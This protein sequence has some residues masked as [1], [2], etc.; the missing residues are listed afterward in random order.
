MT[1]SSAVYKIGTR[2][3]NLALFQARQT[4]AEFARRFPGLAF[5]F[6][7]LDS[8]GD[9]D[10]KTDLRQSPADFFTRD[11]DNAV[12]SGTL[13]C[14]V[15]S[16]KD[17]P[18]PVSE[19]LDWVW[20]PWRADP[21]DALV[22]RQGTS[23]ADLPKAP[24][25]GVSSERRA[26]YCTEHFPEGVQRNLRGNIEERL[27]QLD[28]GDVDLIVMAAAA[29]VRLDL[30]ARISELIPLAEMPVP[31]GQ[32]RLCL[33]F[34]AGDPTFLR[35]RALFTTA[36]RFV[37]A[38]IGAAENATMAAVSALQTCDIC[39]HDSLMDQD[40]LDHL[41]SQARPIYVGKRAGAHYRQQTDINTLLTDAARKGYRVV[42]LKGGDP[43][44]FGRLAEELEALGE[45]NIPYRVVPGLSSLNVLS[46]GSGILLTRRG[47]ANGF[48][49]LT[50]RKAGG[51]MADIS[52]AERSRYPVVAYMS[53]KA[54]GDV[55]EQLVKD[56][57]SESTPAAM[58]FG[59]GSGQEFA[60][61]G[62]LLD[63]P[64]QVAE[65]STDLPG[66][67]VTGAEAAREP[68][69]CGPLRGQRVLLT[70]SEAILGKASREVVDRG[71]VPVPLPMLRLVPT[72]A[73]RGT[74]ARLGEFD[75]LVVTSP[76]SVRILMADLLAAG[77]D[78]RRLP[79]IATCGGGTSAELQQ[80][81]ITPDLCPDYDFGAT[82][83]LDE[84]GALVPEAASV[85][86]V[87]SNKA[88]PALADQLRGA[89]HR[90][91][92]CIAY[93]TEPIT[94]D[95]LPE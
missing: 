70:C 24:R 2:S 13:D 59:V 85:L 80:Y 38:G 88:G 15:H 14:A 8:P 86:R 58:V 17:V 33:T 56:G 95:R 90:V 72:E 9:R 61:R 52:A 18:D 54:C 16:A 30:S 31:E 32:G 48:T 53:V 93:T 43:A 19:G 82:A 75:W 21:R 57:W 45:L 51:G 46:T 83:L 65:T 73:L 63:L 79:K 41:P 50:P 49:V 39:F 6:V 62:T 36:V 12:R 74:M 22:V 26:A 20:L 69:R 77:T 78:L 5:E 4:V 91:E 28:A 87:R 42:R 89:R 68:L 34:R 10:R 35:L 3:S 66:L 47:G 55:C 60:V 44:V 1:S 71:G 25:I 23:V 40:L 76:S 64:N 7:P 81:G 84:F 11:L 29:L 27:R 67:L 37:G 92:E 94:H